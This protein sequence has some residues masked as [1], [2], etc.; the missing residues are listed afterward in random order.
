M[1]GPSYVYGGYSYKQIMLDPLARALN[2][3]LAQVAAENKL[4]PRPDRT[5]PVVYLALQG[6]CFLQQ[7]PA[8]SES[9]S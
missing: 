8:G 9:F 4:W 6:E 2:R 5:R 1:F 7:L 3:A